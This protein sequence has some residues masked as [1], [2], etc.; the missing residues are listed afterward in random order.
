MKKVRTIPALCAF[1]VLAVAIAGCGSGIPGNSVAVV[2]GN[3]ITTRAFNHWMFVVAKTQAAQS[4]GSPVIVPEDPPNFPNCISDV[5][6]EIPTLAKT[7]TKTLRSDCQHVFTEL[8]GIV[9]DYL[10]KAYWY[11]ADA[12]ALGVKITPAQV[13]TALT[14][15]RKSQFSTAAQFN[16]FLTSTGQ[17]VADITYR[18]RVEQIY[19][20]LLARHP[21]KV[22]PAAIAA[23][24]H[25]HQS[26]YGTPETR[27]IRI[28]LAKSTALADAAKAALQ[29]GQSWTKVAKK[30]SID[31]TTKNTGGLLSGVTKGGQDAA[32][33]AAAFAAPLNKL[34]GPVKGQ[35]GYYVIDVIK[36]T[37]AVTRTLAQSTPL[38]RQTLNTQLG[39]SAAAAVLNH[40]KNK[41]MGKTQCRALYAMADCSGYKA[42]KSSSS[43]G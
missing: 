12:H 7:A 19:S 17:T 21:T 40:A 6:A 1:F 34:I 30:Y 36:V 31:P 22:T 41:W 14:A 37:P 2:A 8:A 4:P 13:Q 15:A 24:Y 35:F 11:Q 32:L 38:I 39:N 18:V 10:V 25:A 29:H 9:M 16:A 42:P 20:K 5:R 33:T 28:V 23:Y 27:N 43:S 26:Q 3:P